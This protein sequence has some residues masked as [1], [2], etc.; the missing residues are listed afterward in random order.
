MVSVLSLWLPVLVSAVFVFFVSFIL[1][2][3]FTYHNSDFKGL[4]EEDKVRQALDG[5]RI[6][7]G[8]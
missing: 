2:T 3:V 6:P 1:H 5:I 7:P 4:V 8:D